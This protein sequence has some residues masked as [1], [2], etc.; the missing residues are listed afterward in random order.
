ML[1]N[2]YF[3]VLGV[4]DGFLVQKTDNYRFSGYL[5]VLIMLFLKFSCSIA[6]GECFSALSGALVGFAGFSVFGVFGPVETD[7]NLKNGF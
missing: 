2:P 7:Q 1:D 4:S 5:P 6:P 3:D